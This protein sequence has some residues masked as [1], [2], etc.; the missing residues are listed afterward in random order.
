MKKRKKKIVKDYLLLKWGSL[1]D[2]S[3]VKSPKAIRLI[4][5]WVKLG[6][7]ASAICQK[8]T[9]KQKKIILQII[10]AIDGTIENDWTG[11]IMTKKQAKKYV[12]EYEV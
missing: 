7:C 2:W 12:A 1:K 10:D 6:V 3:G 11:K 5:K 8:N 4:K 9:P